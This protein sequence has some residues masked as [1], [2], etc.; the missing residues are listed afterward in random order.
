MTGAG[1]AA[2]LTTQEAEGAG[3]ETIARKLGIGLEEA[4]KI[5]KL[6]AE[7][8]PQTEWD[9]KIRA[10]QTVSQFKRD[11]K[12]FKKLGHGVD[13]RAF[14]TPSGNVLKE[15]KDLTEPSS[16][17]DVAPS[18]VEQVGLGPKS[19]NIHLGNRAPY[20][21]QDKV[22][23]LENIFKASSRQGQDPE[24]EALYKKSD[25]M[26]KNVNIENSHETAALNNSQEYQNLQNAI[27]VK[28]NELLKKQGIDTESMKKE[29]NSLSPDEKGRVQLFQGDTIESDPAWAFQ[30]L[31]ENKAHRELQ[32]SIIPN[33]MHSGNIGLDAKG[34][35]VVF[36]I[37][38][39][40]DFNPKM[41]NE[42]AKQ[43]IMEVNIALPEKKKAL[44]QLLSGEAPVRYSED[45]FDLKK[46]A[47]MAAVP[48]TG[49]LINKPIDQ[50]RDA[51]SAVRQPIYDA[52]SKVGEYIADTVRPNQD[53]PESAKQQ[54][55]DIAGGITSMALD[56][57]NLLAPG[58]GM[59]FGAADIGLLKPKEELT[60]EEQRQLAIERLR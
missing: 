6:A 2:L 35:P 23:P 25:E 51:Y 14:E 60:P 30:R 22:N 46:A 37:S 9:E 8:L 50:L 49:D 58:A 15:P 11:P 34:N 41:L 12:Q 47:A 3:I 42:R 59:A 7:K 17:L 55:R 32:P 24:L 38:R 18:L 39:F 19:K 28:Q 20:V 40:K 16:V 57:A 45:P 27:Q 56:P 52:T 53:M 44:Q 33:D 21:I 13:Y 1:A 5:K 36:D 43:K 10:I 4:A 31:L 54:E 48:T 29:F 26:W